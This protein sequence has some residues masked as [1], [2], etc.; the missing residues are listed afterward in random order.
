MLMTETVTYTIS[1]E[2][3]R[4]AMSEMLILQFIAKDNGVASFANHVANR[5][6]DAMNRTKKDI[7]N[8][9]VSATGHVRFVNEL[10]LLKQHKTAKYFKIILDGQKEE[11][12]IDPKQVENAKQAMTEM[13]EREKKGLRV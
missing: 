8:L 12:K 6:Y 10:H 5:F 1:R 9:D 4:K 11:K 2:M 3:A 13:D 7:V